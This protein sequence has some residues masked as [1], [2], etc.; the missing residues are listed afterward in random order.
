[1]LK[2]GEKKKTVYNFLKRCLKVSSLW[3]FWAT[4]SGFRYSEKYK[5]WYKLCKPQ[6]YQGFTCYISHV[7][8]IWKKQTNQTKRFVTFSD[9]FINPSF[10]VLPVLEKVIW[11]FYI[12]FFSCIKW[13]AIYKLDIIKKKRKVTNKSLGKVQNLFGE[14]KEKTAIWS[15]TV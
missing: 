15:Q 8:K 10:L 11:F 13:R 6:K 9:L 5:S 3:W 1:M 2:K 14:E 7:L 12:I 4:L